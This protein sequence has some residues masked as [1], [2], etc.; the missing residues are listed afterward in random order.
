MVSGRAGRT[1]EKLQLQISPTLD[2]MLPTQNYRVTPREGN[3]FLEM[4]VA[5]THSRYWINRMVY[6]TLKA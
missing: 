2:T 3:F 1:R 5:G 4:P 6:V